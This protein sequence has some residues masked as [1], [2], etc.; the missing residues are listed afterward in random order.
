MWVLDKSSEDNEFDNSRCSLVY[1]AYPP[2]GVSLFDAITSLNQNTDDDYYNVNSK[3]SSTA[4]KST[5]DD[6]NDDQ[7]N[8][9][10][11]DNKFPFG[12]FMVLNNQSIQ[13]AANNENKDA[14]QIA[15]EV[16][17][18]ILYR[19]FDEVIKDK[20]NQVQR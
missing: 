1:F 2:S 5:C 12:R 8:Q 19:Q 18:T 11:P 6:D 14:N 10:S 9:K 4:S 13:N 3:H 15:Q 16:F 20:W 7:N 17:N